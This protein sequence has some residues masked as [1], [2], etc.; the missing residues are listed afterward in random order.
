MLFLDVIPKVPSSA[1]VATTGDERL[2]CDG[3]SLGETIR[4]GSLELI[5]DRFSRLSLSPLGMAQEPLL[6]VPLAA[7]QSGSWWE[8]PLRGS[9]QLRVGKGGS[10][11]PSQGDTTRRLLQCQPR[12]Y[13]GRRALW[14]IKQRR[15]FHRGKRCRSQTTTSPSSDGGLV[16]RLRSNGLSQLVDRRR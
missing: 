2:S 3:F 12:P 14:L 4:F 10:T 15:P 1:F 11:S 16:R 8:I 6:W 7:G 9:P 13:R 5:T